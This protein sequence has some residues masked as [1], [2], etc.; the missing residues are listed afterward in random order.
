M[1]FLNK[2]LVHYGKLKASHNMRSM[3]MSEV[4]DEHFRIHAG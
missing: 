2:V 4:A 3:T 1:A